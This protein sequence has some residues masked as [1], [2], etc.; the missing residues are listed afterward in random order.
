MPLHDDVAEVLRALD[1]LGAPA[2]GDG[3]PAEARANYDSAPKP[4]PDP[5]VRVEDV[6]IAGPAGEIAC[7][8]YA[9][10]TERGLP[11][12]AFFHGGGWV[13]S[14]VDGHDSLA[15]RIA[16]RSGALVVSVEYRLAPEHPF[17]APHD[18][19][20]AVTRWLS[21]HA[22]DLGGDPA[23]LA[24]AGDSAGGNLA[25]GVALRARDEG[26]QLAHQLLIYPCIDTEQTRPSMS[27]NGD[28]YFLTAADMD[29]FWGH[30]VP[31][32]HRANPYAVPARAEDVSGLA[33]ALVQTAEF[34]P[35][36]DEGEDWGARLAAAGVP[37]EVTRYD[38][39]VHGFVSRW[40]QMAAAEGA[41]DEGCAALRRAFGTD[42]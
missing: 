32:E 23:R 16:K 14:S 1:A 31:P 39:V 15:R 10:S 42:A 30:F 5:L 7:R 3:T 35:L 9:D 40:H 37:V 33:P 34:D 20:W 29:W 25:A 4:D 17:P 2:L 26:L 12:V 36:R 18:D 13:L 38:G 6:T 21:E 24:V 27:E 22:A 28:G 8:V 19:C 41:H 11:V